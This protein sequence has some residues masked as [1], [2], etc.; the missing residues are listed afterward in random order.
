MNF[1]HISNLIPFS[2][3][4]PT[5]PSLHV[6]KVCVARQVFPRLVVV[7][8]NV[9]LLNSTFNFWQRGALQQKKN[10]RNKIL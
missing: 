7:G 8:V 2:P 4:I 5:T 9:S 3:H 10:A 6:G 1:A